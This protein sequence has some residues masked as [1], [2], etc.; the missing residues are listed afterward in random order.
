MKALFLVLFLVAC[1]SKDETVVPPQTVNQ[2][3]NTV[4]KVTVQDYCMQYQPYA[5]TYTYSRCI[6]TYNDGY[7]YWNGGVRGQ[8]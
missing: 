8:F 7:G 5:D 3:P 1:G 6:N 2:L 4:N